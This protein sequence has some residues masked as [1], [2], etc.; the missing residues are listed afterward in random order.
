MIR[1]RQELLPKNEGRSYLCGDN[2]HSIRDILSNNHPY[3]SGS[4][5]LLISREIIISIQ[6][7]P[8]HINLFADV[9]NFPNEMRSKIYYIWDPNYHPNQLKFTE[10]NIELPSLIE[11][12][13]P[14]LQGTKSYLKSLL[15]KVLK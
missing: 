13:F 5:E 4:G 6:K 11:F 9:I 10:W 1:V 15:I 3:S 2:D 14:N 12:D 7:G 8:G